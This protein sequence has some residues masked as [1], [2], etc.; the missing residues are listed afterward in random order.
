MFRKEGRTLIDSSSIELTRL[1]WV[2]NNNNHIIIFSDTFVQRT[3]NR[4][5]SVAD[6]L[7][8][9]AYYRW[10]PSS[11]PLWPLG[12]RLWRLL[13]K[14]F[15]LLFQQFHWRVSRRIQTWQSCWRIM[16]VI[17]GSLKVLS[18]VEDPSS[19]VFSINISHRYQRWTKKLNKIVDYILLLKGMITLFNSWKNYDKVALPREFYCRRWTRSWINNPLRR[20]FFCQNNLNLLHYGD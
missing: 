5:E 3:E 14:K 9:W 19:N 16:E 17:S 11:I 15:I 1:Y 7:G 13:K 8:N 4:S 6:R 20:I 18:F 2:N 12:L 10:I